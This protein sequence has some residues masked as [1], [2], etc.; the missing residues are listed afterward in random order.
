[1]VVDVV[2]EFARDDALSGLL[3]SDDLVLMTETM[4][5]FRNKF[6]K[7]MEA[8]DS[9]SLKVNHGETKV[10]VS[11]SITKDGMPK[12]KVDPCGVCSMRVKVNSVLCV[13][14]GKWIHGRCVR[15]KG[16]T[17]RL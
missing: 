5:G 8:F 15:V 4:D 14:C 1:M 6:L 12:S 16:V 13:Q 9:R 2:T 7:L 17:P 11:S 10:I 3:Y